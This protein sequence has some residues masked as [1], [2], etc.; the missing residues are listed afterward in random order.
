[1]GEKPT[2]LTRSTAGEPHRISCG[3]RSHRREQV[4]EPGARAR[5]H[6]QQD[7]ERD[8]AVVVDLGADGEQRLELLTPGRHGHECGQS[9]GL[10]PRPRCD[11]R[12]QEGHGHCFLVS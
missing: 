9:D 4:R 3:T 12:I 10:C 8:E 2:L 11:E 1:M 7:D 6:A 5:V